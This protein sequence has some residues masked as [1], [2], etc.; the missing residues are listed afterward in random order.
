MAAEHRRHAAD[1]RAASQALRQAEASACNGI[2]EADR[3]QSPF[4]RVEDVESVERLTDPG[5]IPKQP[6][7]LVG[8][9]VTFAAVEGMTAEWLQRVVDCH[10]ARNA[11][12]GHVAS[13]MPTCPLVP[14]GASASVS[15]TG[16]GFAVSIRGEDAASSREIFERAQQLEKMR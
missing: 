8:A 16:H 4:T 13:D 3:D 10:L 15:S 1:H 2:A 11:A 14:K 9:V 12:L 5:G 7:K 6:P